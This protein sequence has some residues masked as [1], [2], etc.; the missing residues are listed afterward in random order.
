MLT[1]PAM[2]TLS[3]PPPAAATDTTVSCENACT[4]TSRW[5]LAF[6]LVPIHACVSLTSTPTSTPAPMPAIPPS[7]TDAAHADL[8]GAVGGEHPHA[9]VGAQGAVPV[10][11]V[12]HRA[13]ADVRLDAL[14]HH[15]HARGAGDAEARPAGQAD[16]D[17]VEVLERGGGDREAVDQDR[18]ALGAGGDQQPGAVAAGVDDRVVADVGRRRGSCRSA[19]R[20]P[21]RHRSGRARAR[22]RTRSPARRRRP[23]P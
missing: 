6:A 14:G 5:A 8:L 7:A 20:R 21:R 13:V 23:R 2:P 17:R 4:R 18:L 3:P 16:G 9:L 12:D 11:L 15:G 19:A 22:R 10:P 1:A